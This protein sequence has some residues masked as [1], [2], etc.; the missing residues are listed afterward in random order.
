MAE[1]KKSPWSPAAWRL[2][3][4]KRRRVVGSTLAGGTQALSDGIGHLERCHLAEGLYADFD[5]ET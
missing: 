1:G 4:L 3:R 2:Y 5:I